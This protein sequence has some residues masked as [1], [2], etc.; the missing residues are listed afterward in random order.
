M[1]LRVPGARLKRAFLSW[2]GRRQGRRK[3]RL[4]FPGNDWLAGITDPRWVEDDDFL[5][6]WLSRVPGEVVELT[7]HPGH[8]DPT[9]VG[10][11]CTAED[12]MLWRRVRE[13]QLLRHPSFLE[14]CRRAGFRLISPGEFVRL[15][16][17]GIRQAA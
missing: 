8:L 10:R 17:R 7:C 15:R 6:R 4:G 3:D 5:V 2:F 1:L 12:G 9:L 11:D 14:S 16:G 13:Y